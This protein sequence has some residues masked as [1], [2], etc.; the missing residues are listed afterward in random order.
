MLF[1]LLLFFFPAGDLIRA[2]VL[3]SFQAWTIYI[4]AAPDVQGQR[5]TAPKVWSGM[6]PVG[7]GRV[8]SANTLLALAGGWRCFRRS[9]IPTKRPRE[10]PSLRGWFALTIKSCSVYTIKYCSQVKYAK[11][12]NLLKFTKIAALQGAADYRL[13][14]SVCLF[15][16]IFAYMMLA[17]KWLGRMLQAAQSGN[18]RWSNRMFCP[19]NFQ[20][21]MVS[22]GHWKDCSFVFHWCE[23][24]VRVPWSNH[25]APKCWTAAGPKTPKEFLGVQSV[26]TCNR[27]GR[28]CWPWRGLFSH[29]KQ[30]K[31]EARSF[32]FA[33][34]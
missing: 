2:A 11:I 17:H 16:K 30:W 33:Q 29:L 31:M 4:P 24:V 27:C 19:R 25:S 32:C 6:G 10:Q 20:L 7:R 14:A 28:G 18:R 9:Q 34:R 26:Q 3:G 15:Y 23:E 12:G 5:T 8:P 1:F 13:K 22:G 21:I